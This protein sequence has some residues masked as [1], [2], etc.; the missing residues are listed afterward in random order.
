MDLHT[1]M[2][3][4]EAILFA[5]GDSVERSALARALEIS[6]EDLSRVLAGLSD[7]YDRPDSGLRLVELEESVQLAT[8][9]ELYDY[10][11]RIAQAPSRP[12]LTDTMLETLS[13]IAYKQPVT[14]TEIEAIRGVNSDF[15]VDKLLSYDLIQELGRKDAPGRPILFGTTE[16]FLRS[17]GVKSVE[18]LPAPKKEQIE[19]L[20]EEA[21]Q[22]ID[23]KLSGPV[24]V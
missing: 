6:G 2:A 23:A 10:L 13:I 19:E 21:E 9:T 18:E 1:A 4:A 15:A 3:A 12:K 20:K 7:K 8:R 16:Q 14:K 5:M 22:E 17:F 24:G 11:I